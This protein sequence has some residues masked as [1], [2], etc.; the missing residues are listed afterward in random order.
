MNN[1]FKFLQEQQIQK[2][3]R[4]V[5]KG[6]IFLSETNMHGK[7]LTPRIPKNFFTPVT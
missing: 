7:T 1:Y 3:S 2:N 5:N 4:Q 6:L